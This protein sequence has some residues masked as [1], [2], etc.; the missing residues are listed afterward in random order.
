MQT[1]PTARRT[2]PLCKAFDTVRRN[3]LW[4]RYRSLG[5]CGKLFWALKAGYGERTL[6]GRLNGFLSEEMPD[7]G[8]GVRQG[9]VDSSDAFALFIDDLD[10][11]IQRLEEDIGRPLGIPLFGTND[12]AKGDRLNALKHADD[13]CII[14]ANVEDARLLLRA[15][16][17]WCQKW[18][19]SPNPDKC[20]VVIFGPR[21]NKQNPHFESYSG[22]FGP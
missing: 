22:P 11:E 12:A 9:E 17:R 13:T 14:A 3:L 7:E 1:H 21:M 4:A 19:I 5:L 8:L 2:I 15:V 10:A 20:E 16:T 6:R 18:A